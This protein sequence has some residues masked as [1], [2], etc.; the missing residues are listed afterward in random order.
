[1]QEL[2]HHSRHKHLTVAEFID[3]VNTNPAPLRHIVMAEKLR[4]SRDGALGCCAFPFVLTSSAAVHTNK[5]CGICHVTPIQGIRYRVKDEAVKHFS[6]CESCFWAG[7]EGGVYKRTM[8]VIEYSRP[9]TIGQKFSN[10]TLRL[11]AVACLFVRF[12]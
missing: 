11:C 12:F 1:M 10:R 2:Y 3:Y 5:E 7:R 4:I 6:M 8:T 9:N